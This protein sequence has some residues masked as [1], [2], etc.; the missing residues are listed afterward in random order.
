[1]LLIVTALVMSQTALSK[2]YVAPTL[3]D[4]SWK[5]VASVFNCGYQPGQACTIAMGQ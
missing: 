2:T 1:V 5:H 4:L 3:P